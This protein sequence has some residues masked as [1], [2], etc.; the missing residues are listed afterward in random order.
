MSLISFCQLTNYTAL[1][2]TKWYYS[3]LSITGTVSNNSNTG[4]L[5]PIAARDT[6]VLNL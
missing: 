1:V 5:I 2:C 4:V 3:N 6:G